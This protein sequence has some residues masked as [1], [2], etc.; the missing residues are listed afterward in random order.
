MAGRDG[1]GPLGE[2]ALT[3]RGL[4]FCGTRLA[5]GRR[6]GYGIGYGPGRSRGRIRGGAR[7]F[8]FGRN[9]VYDEFDDR[10]VKEILTE[11]K[12]ILEDRLNNITDQLED[13]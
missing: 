8:G 9:L 4:G 1:T 7:G 10:S 12:E 13:L 3:G 11:E 2:G 5:R 6:A